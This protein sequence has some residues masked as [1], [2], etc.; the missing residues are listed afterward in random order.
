MPTI[1]TG[2]GAPTS[3]RIFED[4]L[5]SAAD[6]GRRETLRRLKEACDAIE[7]RKVEITG[8]EIQRHVEG[9]YGQRAGPKAQSIRNDKAKRGVP[10]YIGMWQYVEARKREQTSQRTRKTGS[11]NAHLKAIDAINDPTERALLRDLYDRALTAERRVARAQHLFARIA[12]GVE[13]DVWLRDGNIGRG[14]SSPSPSLVIKAE[15]VTALEQVLSS[16]TDTETLSRCGLQYDG[17]RIIRKGPL[18]SVL[19]GLGLVQRLAEMHQYL[20]TN[21]S[22][23][24]VPLK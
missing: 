2:A 24:A 12:P 16:L 21:A 20:V 1:S 11:S 10:D 4:L 5:T 14:A 8:A 23:E 9:I 19:I 15:W 22:P 7:A 3:A 13:F 17:K 6:N 18:A